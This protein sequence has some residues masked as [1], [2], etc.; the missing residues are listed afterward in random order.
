MIFLSIF[1]QVADLRRINKLYND[2]DFYA[3]KT[4]RVPIR[5]HGLF[6][7]ASEREKRRHMIVEHLQK[8]DSTGSGGGTSDDMRFGGPD[9]YYT[10]DIESSQDADDE[11]G[12]SDSP[13][14]RYGLPMYH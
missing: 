5:E 13:E 8:P 3:L 9:M 11:C 6:T 4:I 12:D 10:S 1:P 2:Q 14:Y 7:E